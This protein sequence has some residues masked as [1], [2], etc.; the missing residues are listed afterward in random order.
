MGIWNME[1]GMVA[2]GFRRVLCSTL[3]SMLKLSAGHG[4][5]AELEETKKLR[6]KAE[7][8]KQPELS[9]KEKKAGRTEE[10]SQ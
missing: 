3:L 7:S 9:R 8:W 1:F 10:L 2:F 6:K 5:A 4:Q